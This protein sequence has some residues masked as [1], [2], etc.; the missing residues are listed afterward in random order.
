LNRK[1]D[2]S[3]AWFD[4]IAVAISMLFEGFHGTIIKLDSF[5]EQLPKAGQNKEGVAFTIVALI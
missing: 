4:I 1:R 3:P 5:L 2:P